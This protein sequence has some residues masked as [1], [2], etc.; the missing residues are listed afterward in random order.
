MLK[1]NNLGPLLIILLFLI[2]VISGY[3]IREKRWPGLPW[4]LGVVPSKFTLVLDAPKG[5]VVE[6][7]PVELLNL[8]KDREIEK[9]ARYE[10]E[11]A[12]GKAQ[13][14]TTTYATSASVADL[15]AAYV[16][17]LTDNGYT[18]L[19]TE[20]RSGHSV[21]EAVGDKHALTVDI[22]VSTRTKKEVRIDVRGGV[23]Q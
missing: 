11:E 21:I 1:N 15:F 10:V 12:L 16:E 23:V 19:S 5:T 20:A 14:I 17:Y 2:L 8:V 4:S 7:F 9:S 13:V 6:G 22:S 3:V 18:I